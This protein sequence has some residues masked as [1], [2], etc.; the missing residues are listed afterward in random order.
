MTGA[1]ETPAWSSVAMASST[2]VCGARVKRW[3]WDVI[4]SDTMRVVDLVG[5]EMKIRCSF[6]AEEE[7]VAEKE[8]H[9]P[10]AWMIN[11][12]ERRFDIVIVVIIWCY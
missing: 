5:V 9:C 3:G 4:R 7:G 11:R 6:W 10:N 12:I 8:R 1:P 2:G